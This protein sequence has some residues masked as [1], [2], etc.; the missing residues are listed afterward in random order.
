VNVG[1]YGRCTL[2]SHTLHSYSYE[3]RRMKCV[4]IVLRSRV[5]EKREKEGDGKSK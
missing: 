1:E 5:G 3:N 4:E 2:N